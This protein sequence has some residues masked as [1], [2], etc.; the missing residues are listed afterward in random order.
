MITVDVARAVASIEAAKA[1]LA[2]LIEGFG[3]KYEMLIDLP[4][5]YSARLA[6]F[7]EGTEVGGTTRNPAR[8]VFEYND[9]ARSRVEEAMRA[10]VATQPRFNVLIT[11]QAGAQAFRE[12]GVERLNGG[13]GDLRWD[14][15]ST[16]YAEQKARKGRPS[17]PGVASGEMRDALQ[18]ALVVVRKRS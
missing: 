8:P 14:D 9:V 2:E 1:R 16:K 17:T 10:S 4:P 6:F 12:L 13:G 18:A 11:L 15:L 5:V 7:S 3:S